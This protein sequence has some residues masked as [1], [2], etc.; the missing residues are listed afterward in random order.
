MKNIHFVIV[1]GTCIKEEQ[2]SLCS[3]L[4][5]SGT[6]IFYPFHV[7]LT[8]LFRLDKLRHQLI[9]L[10]YFDADEQDEWESELL[11]EDKEQQG[12]LS[13]GVHLSHVHTKV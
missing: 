9:P 10:Y 4:L 13:A 6:F 7:F 12:A 3:L 2:V 1:G 5:S 11:E 8:F